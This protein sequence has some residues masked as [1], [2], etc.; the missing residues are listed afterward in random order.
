MSKLSTIASNWRDRRFWSERVYPYLAPRP[1]RGVYR[2]YSRLVHGKP[3]HVVDEDWDNL[4]VLDAARFDAFSEACSLPGVLESRI[5]KGCT[6]VGFLN[7]NFPDEYPEVVYATA[8]PHASRL[9]PHRFHAM[10]PV[11]RT[12]WDDEFGTVL[13]GEMADATRAVAEEY[14]DKRLIAH[15]VQ[16]HEPYVGPETVARFGTRYANGLRA[17]REMADGEDGEMGTTVM[18]AFRQGD[19]SREEALAAYR[20]N[21]RLV[22][23]EV[24]DL[25]DDL[26]GKTVVTADHGEMFGERAW[27]FPTRRIGHWGYVRTS[28]LVTVPWFVAEHD[29]RKTVTSGGISRSET[30]DEREREEKLRSLGYL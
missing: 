28:E 29:G 8:N 14:P 11:W 24:A 2:A 20:E 5:S 6:T 16:P 1:K 4:L 9:V 15:F 7:G 30:G 23:D 26:P 22:L 13:P 25:I 12:R 18:A 21:L 27:P 10:V 3:T 19:L 17:A